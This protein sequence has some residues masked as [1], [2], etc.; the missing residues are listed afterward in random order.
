MYFIKNI[1]IEMDSRHFSLPNKTEET[2][3]IEANKENSQSFFYN[4]T[5]DIF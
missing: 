4:F 1:F 5:A 2:L 3:L